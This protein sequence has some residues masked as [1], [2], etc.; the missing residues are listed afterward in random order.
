[1]NGE[2]KKCAEME[3]DDNTTYYNFWDT[4]KAI[5]RGNFISLQ[6]YLKKQEKFQVNN[7]K[8]PLELE[9]EKQKQPKISRRKEIIKIRAE[10]NKI[11]NKK[12]MQKLIQQASSLKRLIKLTT[13]WLDSLKIK[14]KKRLI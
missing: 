2:I 14:G 13:P 7:L 11:E 8:L 4:M 5:T 9:E 12:T 6:A 10:L 1:M 3:E